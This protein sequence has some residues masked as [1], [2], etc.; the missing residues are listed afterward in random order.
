MR[1]RVGL[2][3]ERKV[4]YFNNLLHFFLGVNNQIWNAEGTQ[5]FR[6]KGLF[7]L[8]FMNILALNLSIQLGLFIRMTNIQVSGIF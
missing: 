1:T 2:I 3:L 8:D 4:V 7:I 6:T 5:I